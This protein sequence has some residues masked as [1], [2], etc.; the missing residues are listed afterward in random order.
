MK[1]IIPILLI[2]LLFLHAASYAGPTDNPA[3]Q[4]NTGAQPATAAGP[5]E[6][7]VSKEYLAEQKV[8]ML[9]SIHGKTVDAYLNNMV[10]IPM[11]QDLGWQ[12]SAIEDG[13]E[14]ERSILIKNTKTFRYRWKVS[15]AGE[16]SPLNDRARELMQ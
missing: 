15:H 2:L 5:E 16:V 3:P 10:K 4:Q 9:P 12:V 13:Y 6:P 1:K 8:K 14:V 11:A 7:G